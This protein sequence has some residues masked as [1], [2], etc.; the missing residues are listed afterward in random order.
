MVEGQQQMMTVPQLW[1]VLSSHVKMDV[2]K[3]W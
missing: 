2:Q 1:M 3:D